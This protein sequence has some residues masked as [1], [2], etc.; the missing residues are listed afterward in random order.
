MLRDGDARVSGRQR[1]RHRLG[2][3]QHNVRMPRPRARAVVWI[4]AA[5]AVVGRLP[6]AQWPLRPDEA[7]FLLV[8]RAWQPRPDSMFGTYW[9]DRPPEMI[10]LVR[11]ADRLGG[12]YAL[13]VV[14]AVGVALLVLAC[15]AAGRRLARRLGAASPDR[16]AAWTA[17]ATAALVSNATIDTVSAKG[18]VLAIPLIAASCWLSLAALDERS[19]RRAAAAGL[20]A[21]LAVGL[22]QNLVGGLVFG[23]VLLVA[24]LVLRE[25]DRRTFLRL[26]G[27]ALAGAALPVLVTVGWALAA[28][29]RLGTLTYAVLGFRIDAGAVLAAEPSAGMQIRQG[30]LLAVFLITG[31][32]LVVAL[33]A[34][35]LPRL[36]RGPALV[37]G[38]AVTAM[39]L[40]DGAGVVL[41]GSFWRTY[42]LALVPALALAVALLV[43]DERPATDP[44][45]G[46]RW[47]TRLVV[48]FCVVS[49]V[50]ALAEWQL[51]ATGRYRPTEWAT[52]RAIAGVARPGDTLMVYGGRADI[53][54]ASGL[55]SPYEH[56]WSL[57]MRTLDPDLRQLR[58]LLA[59]P[60]QPTWFVEF[61]ALDTWS[62]AGTRPIAQKLIDDYEFVET[63][64]GRYRIY[65]VNTVERRSIDV[66]CDAP[67]TGLFGARR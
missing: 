3:D 23:A 20:F 27:A 18:E 33:L 50:V 21:A 22:K 43:G 41:S 19:A 61:T 39:L 7:G 65:H 10:A 63:A 52:G 51:E 54:W 64:C 37:P 13:R 26:A 53:Q 29:V 58:E 25:V 66:D 2:A 11:L 67:F 15:A 42:L 36:L 56:L 8:A 38:L 9:V 46:S 17:V 62:E 24:A 5:A 4:A 45:P 60:R 55:R 40:C 44:A 32:A 30:L 28:G 1:L 59:G 34:A 35:R 6:S 16:V 49:S 48:G 12:P 14:A 47:L 57:P 31:M